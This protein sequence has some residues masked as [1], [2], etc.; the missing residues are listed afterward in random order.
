MQ[1][2][3]L[4]RTED[5]LAFPLNKI[6]SLILFNDLKQIDIYIGRA[7]HSFYFD[8]QDKAKQK[9]DEILFLMNEL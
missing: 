4:R 7:V 9:Y 8:T 3:V 5:E 1:M 6:E 2:L